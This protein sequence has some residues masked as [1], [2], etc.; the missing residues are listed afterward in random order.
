LS[1]TSTRGILVAPSITDR[2]ASLLDKWDFEYRS[3]DI[4]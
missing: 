4:E 3:V 1:D 2:T